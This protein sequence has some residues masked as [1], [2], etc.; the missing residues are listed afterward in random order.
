MVTSQNSSTMWCVGSTETVT[1]DVANTTAAPVSAANVNIKLSIDGGLTYPITLAANTPNDGSENIVVPNNP[2]NNN[3]RIMVEAAD[4]IFF[5]I[6]NTNFTINAAPIVTS[7]PA[8]VN[9]EWG[10]N[11][12]F[13]VSFTGTQ[14]Q[15]FNGR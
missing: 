10:D 7:H 8:D 5:D 15:L 9:A 3:A 11:V 13:S 12:S 14:R 1:W 6:N 2:V 4:N